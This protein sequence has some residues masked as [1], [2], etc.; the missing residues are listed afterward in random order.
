MQLMLLVL[1]HNVLIS[2]NYKHLAFF[3]YQK[4]L[5]TGYS[6]FRSQNY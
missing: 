3:S 6:S 1:I 5:L 4:V 2:S